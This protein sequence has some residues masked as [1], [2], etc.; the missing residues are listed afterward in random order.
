VAASTTSTVRMHSW[1]A[2]HRDPVCGKRSGGKLLQ[3]FSGVLELAARP[4][5]PNYNMISIVRYTRCLLS[6]RSP[7][8]LAGSQRRI[9]LFSAP[10]AELKIG[11]TSG[12]LLRVFWQL[13]TRA[14]SAPY[15]SI[16]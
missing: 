16:N 11:C 6:P 12:L 10:K 4:S 1:K 5:S 7:V 14:T 15:N 8:C 2:S 9:G 13:P 3:S